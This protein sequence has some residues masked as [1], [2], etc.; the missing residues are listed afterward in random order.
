MLPAWER[1][2]AGGDD[3]TTAIDQKQL[4]IKEIKPP[5]ANAPEA[6]KEKPVSDESIFDQLK[7]AQEQRRAAA[8][9]NP[10]DPAGASEPAP[11]QDQPKN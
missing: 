1:R 9:K 5:V 11:A 8:T 3:W 2:A 7:R 4:E 10:G 6:A